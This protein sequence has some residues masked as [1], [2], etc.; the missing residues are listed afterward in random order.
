MWFCPLTFHCCPRRMKCLALQQPFCPSGGQK[1]THCRWQ[2]FKTE[3]N[4]LNECEQLKVPKQFP[5][6]GQG[7]SISNSQSLL[8]EH[9]RPQ[10][11]NTEKIK[12]IKIKLILTFWIMAPIA[13]WHI[14]EEAG[15]QKGDFSTRNS[16]LLEQL[17]SLEVNSQ[18]CSS[19]VLQTFQPGSLG[20]WRHLK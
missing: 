10:R 4:G 14:S 20:S 9:W 5:C 18:D 11:K 6:S 8:S 3:R 19:P 17:L 1:P 2:S 12:I 15:V 7:Y 16:Q 13:G